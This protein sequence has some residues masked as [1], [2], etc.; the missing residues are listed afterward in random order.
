MKTRADISSSE[1]TS[2]VVPVDPACAIACA[3]CAVPD[4]TPKRRRIMLLMRRFHHTVQWD[5]L[6]SHLHR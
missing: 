3:Q 4:Q 6:I 5:S 2:L 1:R